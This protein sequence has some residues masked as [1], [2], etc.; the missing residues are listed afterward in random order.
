MEHGRMISDEPVSPPEKSDGP[1]V[2]QA[3]QLPH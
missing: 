2:S 3:A 1:L